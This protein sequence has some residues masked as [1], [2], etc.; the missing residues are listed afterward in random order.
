MIY[1]IIKEMRGFMLSRYY[2][3]PTLILFMICGLNAS[4][5]QQNTNDEYRALLNRPDYKKLE[6][7]FGTPLFQEVLA[8]YCSNRYEDVHFF[9]RWSEVADETIGHHYVEEQKR[10]FL[11]NIILHHKTKEDQL[12]R[13]YS[14]FNTHKE[15]SSNQSVGNKTPH[16]IVYTKIESDDYTKFKEISNDIRSKIFVK[17]ISPLVLVKKAEGELDIATKWLFFKAGAV[18]MYLASL[19]L[20][21]D[22]KDEK[23]ERKNDLLL[24]FSEISNVLQGLE[25]ATQKYLEKSYPVLEKYTV[26][27]LVDKPFWLYDR[28]NWIKGGSAFCMVLLAYALLNDKLPDVTRRVC[29]VILVV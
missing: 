10:Y 6:N 12:F 25:E 23:R 2:Y 29:S 24:S 17:G 21:K 9:E 27:S 1:H 20:K 14:Y 8:G 18:I 19:C 16:G 22:E 28:N 7:E 13:L 11:V 4:M 5:Y 26:K 3:F 15:N